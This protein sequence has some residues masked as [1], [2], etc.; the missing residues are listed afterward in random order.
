MTA[1]RRQARQVKQ[2]IGDASF[3]RLAIGG[4]TP[5]QL[6]LDAFIEVFD[7]IEEEMG[8]D[9]KSIPVSCEMSPETVDAEKVRVMIE[10]GVKR[11]SIGVQSFLEQETRAV[12][13]PQKREDVLRALTTVA[14]VLALAALGG[15][16]SDPTPLRAVTE[17]VAEQHRRIL[18]DTT[19][20]TRAVLECILDGEP[21]DEFQPGHALEHRRETVVL[22]LDGGAKAVAGGVKVGKQALDVLL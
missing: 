10:R 18:V 14:G 6:D 11:A 15:E 5:T 13:R 21:L 4:G 1:L 19:D 3:A 20:D 12:R 8:A 17:S 16:R 22:V 2:A 9:I 7:I